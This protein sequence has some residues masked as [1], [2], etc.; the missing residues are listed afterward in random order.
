MVGGKIDTENRV[1]S[2]K[3]ESG[4]ADAPHF[5]P[6]QRGIEQLYGSLVVSV[7]S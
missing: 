1:Q 7:W 3:F 6:Q 5:T 4:R 2:S